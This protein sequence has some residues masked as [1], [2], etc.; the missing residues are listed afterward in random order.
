MGIY[1]YFNE[2]AKQMSIIDIKLGVFGGMFFALVIAK[3]VSQI[4]EINIWWYVV[5][6]I[7]FILKPLYVFYLKK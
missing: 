2:R 6:G 5:L 7:L 4:M 1:Q 3:L